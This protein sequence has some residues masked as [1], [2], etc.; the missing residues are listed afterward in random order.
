MINKKLLYLAVG[1]KKN[2]NFDEN[3]YESLL[4]LFSEIVRYF[5]RR[6]FRSSG[7]AK[8]QKDIINLV[9]TEKPDYVFL[10]T[11]MY[12]IQENTLKQIRAS[13]ALIFAWYSDD[14]CRFDNY[15]KYFIPLVD[16]NITTDAAS[17]QK[18]KQL[19]AKCVLSQWAVNHR[20]YKKINKKM[21]YDVSFVGRNISNRA[22]FIKKIINENINVHTFGEGWNGIISFDEV[23]NVINSSKINLNF[24]GSYMSAEI[25]QI[26]GRNFEIPMCGGFCLTE[27]IPGIEEFYKIDKEIVC[28]NSIEEAIHKIKYYLNNE[29][30]RKAIAQAGWERAQREHTWEKRMSDIFQEILSDIEKGYTTPKLQMKF[31]KP[32]NISHMISQYHYNHAKEWFLKNR[33]DLCRN[34]INISLKENP[35]NTYSRYLSFISKLPHKLHPIS[36]NIYRYLKKT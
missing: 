14:H 24:S 26:K 32:K 34:E 7:I 22:I 25:K 2:Y 31:N 18:Y 15:S 28:F 30:E 20:N 35:K 4:N 33:I 3:V 1:N 27:Y 29:D 9:K 5:Y 13:G 16:Y 6:E 12:E 36:M 19:G 11:S 23:I 17:Y 21:K 10:P 8:V